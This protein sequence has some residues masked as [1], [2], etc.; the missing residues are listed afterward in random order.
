MKKNLLLIFLLVSLAKSFRYPPIYP[1]WTSGIGM[2]SNELLKSTEAPKMETSAKPI[3]ERKIYRHMVG[4]FS[5]I[6]DDLTKL[7]SMKQPI[8]F[9]YYV[10]IYHHKRRIFYAN[11]SQ[12]L[13]FYHTRLLFIM[14]NLPNGQKAIEGFL[15][16]IR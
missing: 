11:F 7:R 12:S 16:S 14:R 6:L 1:V 4:R 10:C 5:R 15:N 2:K 13:F 3:V 8:L 9:P